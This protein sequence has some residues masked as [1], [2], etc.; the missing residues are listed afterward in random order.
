MNYQEVFELAKSM[1]WEE[2]A[3]ELNYEHSG[4]TLRKITRTHLTPEQLQEIRSCR[5]SSNVY[6]MHKR[7]KE[8]PTGEIEEVVELNPERVIGLHDKSPEDMLRLAGFDPDKF[9]LSKTYINSYDGK[10]SMRVTAEPKTVSGLDLDKLNEVFS[11][12]ITPV[13]TKDEQGSVN[14]VLPL[15]D[16]HFGFVDPSA[17][18]DMI[19]NIVQVL[20]AHDVAKLVVILG[21]DVLHHEGN[22]HTSSGT[23]VQPNF[24]TTKMV[25]DFSTWLMTLVDTISPLVNEINFI[26]VAGNHDLGITNAV[27]TA[28][29]TVSDIEIKGLGVQEVI[30]FTLG[31]LAMVAY[32][33][34][35]TNKNKIKE[36]DYLK[37]MSTDMPHVLSHAL[38]H[39]TQPIWWTGHLHGAMEHLDGVEIKRV[40]A[41][42]QR[43]AY[44]LANGFVDGKYNKVNMY[45]F[46]TDSE[47]GRLQVLRG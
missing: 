25:S 11:N 33:G 34:A 1:T 5:A 23:Y 21:G 9:E 8:T 44:E 14:A 37:V 2:V 18:Q 45:L 46:D 27:L 40:P 39:G 4:E 29:S 47:I 31:N 15:Y 19:Q 6:K 32:H 35:G 16:L 43:S 41:V 22:G 38:E 17:Y 30:S 3:H 10:L 7:V 26:S 24:D 12:Y 28:F 42:H 13:Y 36:K 20:N